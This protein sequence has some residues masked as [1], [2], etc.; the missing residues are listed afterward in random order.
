M[1]RRSSRGAE[2]DRADADERR[3]PWTIKAPSPPREDPE[4]RR[5]AGANRVEPDH[6]ARAPRAA[7]GR[8]ARNAD[9]QPRRDHEAAR[10]GASA[11]P[12]AGRGGGTHGLAAG[13]DPRPAV[14]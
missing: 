5:P 2:G 3:A 6:P 11:L 8:A 7:R 13:R 9:P 1:T 12:D 10:R 4:P 14:G